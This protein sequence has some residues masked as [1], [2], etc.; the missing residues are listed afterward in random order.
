MKII[1]TKEELLDLCSGCVERIAQGSNC[2]GCPFEPQCCGA[3][4]D[5]W[6]DSTEVKD[7]EK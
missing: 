3:Y 7:N 1:V 6:R 4:V 2:E 5:F